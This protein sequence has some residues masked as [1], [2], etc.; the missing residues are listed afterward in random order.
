MVDP[1]LVSD[2]YP[3][4]NMCQLSSFLGRWW[5]VE[6]AYNNLFYIP[7]LRLQKNL[8]LDKTVDYHNKNPLIHIAKVSIRFHGEYIVHRILLHGCILG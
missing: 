1:L 4:F 6:L 7:P 2:R 3:S 8:H 5:G